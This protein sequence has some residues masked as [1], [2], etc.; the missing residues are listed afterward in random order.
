MLVCTASNGKYSQV[1]PVKRGSVEDDI[2]TA[3]HGTDGPKVADIS[4]PEFQDLLEI[5][6]DY[7]VR[8]RDPVHVLEFSRSA[9]SP[10]H[11]D[12]L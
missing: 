7:F 8:R 6:V 1:V 2:Y 9:A 3:Q 11:E 10:H 12:T 4:D 5:L